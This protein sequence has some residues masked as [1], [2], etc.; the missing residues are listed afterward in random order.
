MRWIGAETLYLIIGLVS[1]N[2]LFSSY[3]IIISSLHSLSVS[4][5]FPTIWTSLEDGGWSHQT[6]SLLL[7]SFFFCGLS[8]AVCVHRPVREIDGKKRWMV[9][10][11][12]CVAQHVP[13]L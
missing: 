13:Y 5:I 2:Y 7:L 3:C 11:M 6:L 8:T 4:H 1:S 12:V 9:Y 10:V